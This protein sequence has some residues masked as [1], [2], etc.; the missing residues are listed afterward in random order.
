VGI[1]LSGLYLVAW[2]RATNK[3]RFC[4]NPGVL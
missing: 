2:Q 4:R 3:Q 1:V